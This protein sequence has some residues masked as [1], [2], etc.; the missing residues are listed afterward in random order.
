[1]QIISNDDYTLMEKL[2]SLSQSGMQKVMSNYLKSKYTNVIA[3][4]KYIVAVGD[5]PV[6]LVA[7]MD[8]VFKY[9]VDNMY[10]D[11]RKG[12]LWSPEGLGADD[13]AGIFAIIK[14]LQSGLRPSVIL[15]TDEET[16]GLGASALAANPCPIPNLKYMI[17]LDRRGTNDCVFYDCYNPD[18]VDYVEKFG[19]VE[20][21]GTFSDISVLMPAWKICGVNLSVGYEDEHSVS[22]VLFIKPL[23][24]T[25]AKVK[26]MLKDENIPTFA[27]A[28]L[29]ANWYNTYN[30]SKVQ[31]AGKDIYDYGAH[32]AQCKKLF[33][34][35]EMYPAKA[36]NDIVKL[37]CPDCIVDHVEW[38]AICGEAYEV[39]SSPSTY[40]CAD[41]LGKDNEK[42]K[43][44]CTTTSKKSKNNS[45]K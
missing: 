8:T 4:E 1:M 42:G 22:E 26:H 33:S 37:Y 14:V 45:K 40:K 35:Y 29:K 10:Y 44:K 24:N 7:H 32:C 31:T 20:R 25:I 6:A 34:E 12:V 27:Y 13:R 43:E 41:C 17:Q 30:W 28:E 11:Q 2:V 3:T 5:I 16:G 9:P 15:T 39:D 23:Y 18:F 38:C 19:F 36:K 21:W